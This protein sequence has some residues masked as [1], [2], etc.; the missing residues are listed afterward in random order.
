MKKQDSGQPEPGSIGAPPLPA[1]RDEPR[2]DQDET[3][4]PGDAPAEGSAPSHGPQF[5]SPADR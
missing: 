2:R 4:T 5:P 1:K 3:K